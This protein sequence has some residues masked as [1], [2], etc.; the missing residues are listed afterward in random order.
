M[1]SRKITEKVATKHLSKIFDPYGQFWVVL[2]VCLMAH[3]TL[4]CT[5]KDYKIRA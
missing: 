5:F 1:C 4:V 3:L 2:F